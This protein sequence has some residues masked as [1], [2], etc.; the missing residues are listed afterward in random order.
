MYIIVRWSYG[1]YIYEHVFLNCIY[2][3]KTVKGIKL[4]NQRCGKLFILPLLVKGFAVILTMFKILA[5]E[6]YLD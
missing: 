5:I 3:Q 6:L 4:I 1:K 2:L